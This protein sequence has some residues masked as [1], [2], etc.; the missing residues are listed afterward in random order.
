MATKGAL[1][2]HHRTCGAGRRL[3][4][5]RRECM[6]C[7]CSVNFARYVCNCRAWGGE[8]AVAGAGWGADGGSSAAC[9]GGG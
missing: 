9:V 3:E 4:E 6:G 7:V 8:V 1:V 5:K 2:S